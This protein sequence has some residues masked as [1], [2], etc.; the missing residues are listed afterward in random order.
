MILIDDLLSLSHI[1]S[2]SN[3]DKQ[4]VSTREITAVA[5][6]TIPTQNHHVN[7]TFKADTVLASRQWLEQIIY[8]LVNNAVKYTPSGSNIDVIWEKHPHFILLTI[9]D[10]GEGIPLQHQNRIFERFYRVQED[11]SRDKGGTGIGLSI[12]K[13]VMEKHGGNVYLTSRR[14]GKGAKFTCTFPR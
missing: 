3:L 7:F 13:Q 4:E 12:V 1:D 10:D 9:K 6:E 2:I 14:R 5:C 8:N 11:R